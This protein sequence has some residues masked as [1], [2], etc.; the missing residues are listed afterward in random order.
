MLYDCCVVYDCLPPI[1]HYSIH[2]RVL[3]A[4]MLRRNPNERPSATAILAQPFITA[5]IQQFLSQSM[6]INEFARNPNPVYVPC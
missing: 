1:R 4:S 2:L 5:R 6:L 3:V